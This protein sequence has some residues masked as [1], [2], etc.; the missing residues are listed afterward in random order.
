L[1]LGI[2]AGGVPTC[3]SM[4]GTPF[5]SGK[6]RQDRLAEFVAMVAQ[7]LTTERSSFSGKYYSAEDALMQP[8]SLQVPRLPLLVA[9]HGPRSLKVAAE[10]GDTWSFFEPGAGLEGKDAAEAICEMNHYIDEKAS[11]AGRDPK[12]ITRSYCCGFSASS[13]WDSLDEALS[14]IEMFEQAGVDE[15]IL[16]Y[17]SDMDLEGE[18]SLELPS[19]TVEASR[20]LL[21]SEKDLLDFAAALS[22]SPV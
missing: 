3:H 9:A 10:Y 20:T 21:Q 19:G 15:F 7:L 5:W 4:T 13:A 11:A 12:T 22:L 14:D 2:G 16:G 6:E 1:T 17:G 18:T 8:R